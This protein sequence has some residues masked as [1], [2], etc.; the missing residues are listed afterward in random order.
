VLA[1]SKFVSGKSTAGSTSRSRNAQMAQTQA[2][3][4]EARAAHITIA[5]I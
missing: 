4:S 2:Q 5:K 1:S 3:L